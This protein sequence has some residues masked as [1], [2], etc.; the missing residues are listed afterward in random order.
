MWL[1]PLHARLLKRILPAPKLFADDPPLPVLD[2]G[3]ERTRTGRLWGYAV[4]DRPGQDP[5]RRR[6]P[7][8]TTRTPRARGQRPTSPTSAASCRST[9]IRAPTACLRRG[10]PARCGSP[11]LQAWEDAAQQVVQAGEPLGLRREQIAPPA[12]QQAQLEVELAG[13][14]PTQRWSAVP[15]Q[16]SRRGGAPG[17]LP[18]QPSRAASPKTIPAPPHGDAGMPGSPCQALRTQPRMVEPPKDRGRRAKSPLAGQPTCVGYRTDDPFP[19]SFSVSEGGV[20][21]ADKLSTR[22]RAMPLAFGVG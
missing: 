5:R 7:S 13:R 4:D 11:T 16:R 10:A 12:D 6:W 22:G 3:G 20:T 2:P 9:P 1:A 18:R 17:G 14:R 8:S 21:N 19:P 15:N